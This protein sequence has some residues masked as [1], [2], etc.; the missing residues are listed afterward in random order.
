MVRRIYIHE[1][2]DWPHFRWSQEVVGPRLAD[3][4]FRQGLLLGR[5]RSIGFELRQ[6]A[7]LGTLTEDVVKSSDIEGEVLPA[8]QVRSSVARRLGLQVAGMVNAGRDVDGMVELLLD[9]TQRYDQPLTEERLLGWH[10][11]LFP[12]GFSGLTR[13]RAGEWRN[14]LSDPMQVVSG[15]VGAERVHFEAPAADRLPG[16]IDSFIK[17]FDSPSETD[18][19]LRAGVA[20]L[21][22][23]TIHPF[24][25]GNGRIARAIADMALARAENSPHRFYSM[26]SQIRIERSRYY[27]TLE[28][29][30]RGTPDVTA[31]L[32]WFLDC[33]GRAID[34]S[35]FTLAKVL[36]KS[37]FWEQHNRL[38]MN[39]RQRIIINLLLDGQLD[40][41]TSSRWARI[42]RCSQDTALRD[43]TALIE[44]GILER[45]AEG[46]R[47]TSY[48]LAG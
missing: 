14:R 36:T 18:P 17:W 22:F 41:L 33:L 40:K 15:P 26:A 21:W 20:H 37:R 24:E 16:E 25:D 35:E 6:E 38:P 42:V 28:S 9:A 31:W 39:E 1:Q 2:P 3:V 44:L 19:V 4:R 29:V 8:S 7:V 45:S 32:E 23:V 12:T 5:M 11:A 46:G 13:I 10:A 48:G 43:I 27:R 47:S 30:Q 34:G